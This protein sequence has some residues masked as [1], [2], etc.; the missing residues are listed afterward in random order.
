AEKAGSLAWKLLMRGYDVSS[1]DSGPT[2]TLGPEPT[3]AETPDESTGDE[4]GLQVLDSV[5]DVSLLDAIVGGVVSSYL[6]E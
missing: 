3:P 2:P 5:P 4:V 6:G 1:S